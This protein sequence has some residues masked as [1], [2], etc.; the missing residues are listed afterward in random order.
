MLLRYAK[1]DAAQ[2]EIL[3]NAIIDGR[4]FDAVEWTTFVSKNNTQPSEAHA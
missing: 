3:F 2:R 1:C 4:F